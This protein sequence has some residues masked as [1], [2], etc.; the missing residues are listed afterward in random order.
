MP[1]R[2]TPLT[3]KGIERLKPPAKSDRLTADGG[4]LYFRVT[5]SG[6]RSWVYRY[7]ISGKRRDMGLGPYPDVGLAEARERALELRRQVRASIDPVEENRTA[8]RRR[9]LQRPRR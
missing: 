8:R 1:K 2:A 3:V 5:P 4:G 6:G 9:A 7:M